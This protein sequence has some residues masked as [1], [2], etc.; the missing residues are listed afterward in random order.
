[1]FIK[2]LIIPVSIVFGFFPSLAGAQEEG[3]TPLSFGDVRDEDFGVI[4][5][6]SKWRTNTIPVCW[7]N[8]DSENGEYRLTVRR[9]VEE[10]WARHSTL[11]FEGWGRCESESRGIHIQI[12]DSGPHVKAL[13]RYLGGMP[14]GMVLNFTFSNWSASCQR[15]QHFCVYAIAVHEFGHAIGFTHEQNRDDA[16]A[17]CQEEA[18]G[19]NGDFKVTRYDPFSI[20]NY[21]NPT[22]NG[23]GQLSDLD[24]YSVKEIYGEAD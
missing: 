17:E 22:W 11:E 19:T 9:A 10:T 20:M 23:D 3:S 18:Q 13:G 4:L 5:K 6:Q 7:E 24:V 8:P 2:Y 15:R 16:P 21:C 1:M 12:A 14:N